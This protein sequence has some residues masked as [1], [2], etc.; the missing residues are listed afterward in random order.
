MNQKNLPA[1][2][3]SELQAFE[4]KTVD[5]W[6][7]RQLQ[8]RMRI[9]QLSMPE[10]ARRAAEMGGILETFSNLMSVFGW[11][12]MD[13]ASKNAVKAEW[14]DQ[15]ESYGLDEIKNACRSHAGASAGKTP[16]LNA[17]I[18]KPIIIAAHKEQVDDLGGNTR[19][20][21]EVPVDET[22]VQVSA[23]RRLEDPDGLKRSE[24]FA[25]MNFPSINRVNPGDA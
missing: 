7:S 12:Q 10:V 18:I 22:P 20:P 11:A 14:C 24:S 19:G 25:A 23:R 1:M 5:E 2:T 9:S 16:I 13:Q 8:K 3:N 6:A 21:M 4:P 15:L 17:E